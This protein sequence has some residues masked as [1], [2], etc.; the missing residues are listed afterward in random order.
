MSRIYLGEVLHNGSWY[1]GNH[2]PLITQAEFDAA[3][4]GFVPGRTRRSRELLSGR[5]RCGLCGRV[6]AVEY[7][8][9]GTP[10]FRCKHRGVGCAMPRRNAGAVEKAWIIGLRLLA[11]DAGLRDA[12][13]RQLALAG[14][15]HGPAARAPQAAKRP[16]ELSV[17][18]LEAQ[19]RKL[20]ELYYADRIGADL[21]AEEEARLR[22]RIGIQRQ[23]EAQAA[24]EREAVS[25]AALKFEEVAAV[26]AEL[27]LATAWDAATY[28]ERRVL[29]EELLGE[30]S[31]FP[32]HLEVDLTKVALTRGGRAR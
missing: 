18:T 1:P 2:Q 16:G 12:I 30:V 3:H 19:R 10:V 11:T 31:L 32:D 4:K 29:V 17:E 7:R 8:Q 24:T 15:A 20:L 5:V 27:D 28:D 22:E 23:Q 6:A 21:F 9:N 26:L 13:R 25:E 14:G